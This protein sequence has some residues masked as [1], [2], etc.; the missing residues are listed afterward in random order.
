MPTV[1]AGAV[2]KTS[3]GVDVPLP[4]AL[5]PNGGLKAELV[6]TL[7][8]ENQTDNRMMIEQAFNFLSIPT[9][10][11]TLVKS[12]PGKLAR[13][14]IPTLVASATVKVYDSLTASGAV[15]MDTLTNPATLLD[16]GPRVIEFGTA[17][18]I[19]LTIVTAGA[20]QPINVIYL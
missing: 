18:S 3:A 14:I 13:I 10:T 11:T 9:Q 1:D 12:G 7:A 2:L 16:Q 6:S 19:G 17:F 4:A 15:M 20:T 5:G 8:G